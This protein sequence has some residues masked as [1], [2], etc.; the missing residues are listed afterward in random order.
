LA[1]IAVAFSARTPFGQCCRIVN[2]GLPN[3]QAGQPCLKREFTLAFKT[4]A[5]DALQ[6]H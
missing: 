3:N 5:F 4:A 1:L 2:T 6:H